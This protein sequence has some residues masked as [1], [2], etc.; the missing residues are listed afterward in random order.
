MCK[1]TGFTSAL[2]GKEYKQVISSTTEHTSFIALRLYLRLRYCQ[3]NEKERHEV[4][5][6]HQKE[7]S[8]DVKNRRFQQDR[9]EKCNRKVASPIGG[10]GDRYTLS[11]DRYT[12]YT[13]SRVRN[14]NDNLENSTLHYLQFTS[15]SSLSH[16]RLEA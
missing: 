16:T 14:L 2:M 13:A 12:R 1:L 15:S 6:A 7:S 8:L 11:C 4:E 5:S 9:R 3:Q 10:G